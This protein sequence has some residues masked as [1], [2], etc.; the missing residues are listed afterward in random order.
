MGDFFFLLFFF[1]R[2]EMCSKAF[3]RWK[4]VSRFMGVRRHLL[5]S[6]SSSCL[7]TNSSTRTRT[8]ASCSTSCGTGALR[9]CTMGATSA[10]CSTVCL[11]TRSCGPG[12][13]TRPVGR[14]PPGSSS[15]SWKSS[16][17]GG[18]GLCRRNASCS[19]RPSSPALAILS[20]RG[21]VWCDISARAMAIDCRSCLKAA[22]SRRPVRRCAAPAARSTFTMSTAR[23][24]LNK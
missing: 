23:G 13:S 3:F 2:L 12:G 5:T 18:G 24:R 21:A 1:F 16:G 9:I 15:H 19:S 17:W 8:S 20:P 11:G 4:G 10:I 6:S 7:F 22:R 14:L